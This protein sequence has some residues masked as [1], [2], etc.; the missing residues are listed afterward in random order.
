MQWYYNEGSE[1][2]GPVSQEELQGL[3]ARGVVGPDN[4]AW[5][6]GMANW[7]RAGDLPELA[8]YFQSPPASPEEAAEEPRQDPPGPSAFGQAAANNSGSSRP[9]PTGFGSYASGSSSY[10]GAAQSIYG[11]RH[12]MQYGV[13]DNNGFAIASLVLGILSLLMFCCCGFVFGIPGIVCGHVARAQIRESDGAQTGDGIALAGLIVG[14]IGTV[15]SICFFIYG[16]VAEPNHPGFQP[17]QP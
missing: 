16:M 5:R 2:R 12:R 10:S 11:D 17:W 3:I 6:E 13:S 9:A 7:V 15:L 4:L 1:R 8:P 14:Y